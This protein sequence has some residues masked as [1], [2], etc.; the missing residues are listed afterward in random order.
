M[1][2]RGAV[3]PRIVGIVGILIVCAQGIAACHHPYPVAYGELGYA[4]NQDASGRETGFLLD[5]YREVA[6]RTGCQFRLEKV[7]LARAARR[8]FAGQ[9][10]VVGPAFTLSN[11]EQ[12]KE[13]HFI[14]LMRTSTELIVLRSHASL[15]R[16][17]HLGA[18]LRLGV[19]NGASYGEWVDDWLKTIPPAQ[20][21]TIQSIESL[22]QM[23]VLHRIHATVGNA[24]VYKWELDRRGLN[25][26]VRVMPMPDAGTFHVGIA[27]NMK[28]IHP[29]DR[30]TLRHA[31]ETLRDDGTFERIVARYLGDATAREQV[32]HWNK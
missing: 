8:F 6:R 19:L 18:G 25:N 14:P 2:G 27:M 16:G 9:S 32:R 31:F 23:M 24:Y 29:D 22:F 17:T 15:I 20:V 10:I 12:E 11:P 13:I 28:T 5:A 30:E 3:S 21:H 4:S 7:P 1:L 26:Y